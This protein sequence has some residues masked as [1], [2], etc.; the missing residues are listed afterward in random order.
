MD[1]SILILD[2][3][4]REEKSAKFFDLDEDV[5]PL[6]EALDQKW[7]DQNQMLLQDNTRFVHLREQE[8]N[9]IVRSIGNLNVIFK[10]LAQVLT[11]FK[12]SFL[13]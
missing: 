7:S 13:T 8:I 11:Y 1:I 12:D 6:T 2:L 10:E 9:E 3:S 5:D 4:A